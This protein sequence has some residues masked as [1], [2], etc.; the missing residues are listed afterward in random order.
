MFEFASNHSNSILHGLWNRYSIKGSFDMY[1][2][3]NKWFANVENSIK[4]DI[5]PSAH[6]I[7]KAKINLRILPKISEIKK[8]SNK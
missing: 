6:K 7:L 3:E 1:A 4:S 8:E 5:L 2:K